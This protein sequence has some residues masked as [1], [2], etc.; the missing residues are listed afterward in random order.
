MKIHFLGTC[1]GTEPI[2]GMC[3]QSMAIESGEKV[4]FFDAG[5]NCSRTAHLSGINLLNTRAIFISHTHMDHVGGLG[6]LLWNIRKL[7]GNV[8]CNITLCEKTVYISDKTTYDG[9][10]QILENSENGY[11]IA[12]KLDCVEI[13]FGKVFSDENISVYAIENT[14]LTHQKKPSYSFVVECEG[15]K[16][17]YSGDLGSLKDLD[18]VIANGCD[19]LICETGHHKVSEVC[20]YA[21]TKNVKALYFSHNGREIINYPTESINAA[22]NIFGECV[23]IAHDKMT[24]EI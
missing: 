18:D 3:H 7:H 23:Y 14:H 5:E 15:R 11:D 6:N 20:E 24:V 12:F 8:G 17:V 21:R 10:M 19:I 16:L 22:R 13:R 1:A 9:I 4:Y 2:E